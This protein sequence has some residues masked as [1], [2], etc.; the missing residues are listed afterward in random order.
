MILSLVKEI[1]IRRDELQNDII[2]T[3]YFGG[4]TP[5]VLSVSEIQA[6][7]DAVYKNHNVTSHYIF[8]R[9]IFRYIENTFPLMSCLF[10]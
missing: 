1:E 10:F 7:I 3:V 4:G 5:S 6:L 2:E 8:L 9:T